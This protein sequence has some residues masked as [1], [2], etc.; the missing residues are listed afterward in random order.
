MA[1]KKKSWLQMPELHS[2]FK[3]E[4]LEEALIKKAMQ[5]LSAGEKGPHLLSSSQVNFS[6][7][8]GLPILH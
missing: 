2:K 8:K 7:L 6:M 3:D 1:K 5:F 4:N